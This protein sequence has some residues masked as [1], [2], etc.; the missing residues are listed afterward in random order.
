MMLYSINYINIFFFFFLN[1]HEHGCNS[2]SGLSTMLEVND[3]TG[4]CNTVY[5]FFLKQI[6]SHI[7]VKMELWSSI[8]VSLYRLHPHICEI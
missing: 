3:V 8:I 7:P 4:L 1:L 2:R 5:S 6:Y